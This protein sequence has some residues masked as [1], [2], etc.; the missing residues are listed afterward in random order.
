MSHAIS[1]VAFPAQSAPPPAGGGSSQAR[2][3]VVTPEPQ[4]TEQTVPMDQSDHW[5]FTG[6]FW[7]KK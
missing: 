5:P 6:I 7:P 3:L 4:V 1:S 2:L